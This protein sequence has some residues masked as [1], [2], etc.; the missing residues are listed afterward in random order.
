MRKSGA[1]FNSEKAYIM[2]LAKA[3]QPAAYDTRVGEYGEGK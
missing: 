1:N 2:I 3:D